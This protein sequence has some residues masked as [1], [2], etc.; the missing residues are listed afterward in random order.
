MIKARF[1]RRRF[2]NDLKKFGLKVSSSLDQATKQAADNI[3]ADTNTLDSDIPVIA[4][5]TSVSK[6]PIGYAVN[7][8]DRLQQPQLAAYAE[9]GTGN[10]AGVLLGN[11][12]QEWK[13][14]AR[15]FFVNGQGR[16]PAS[17]ALYPSFVR[18]SSKIADEAANKI[19]A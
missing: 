7:K 19:N 14:M 17:P 18:H 4:G 3:A 1:D 2:N 6:E 13:D 10:Y 11:Y 12:P 5:S 15:R 9:F 8:G 16:L